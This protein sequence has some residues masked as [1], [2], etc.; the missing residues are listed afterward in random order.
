M[1]IEAGNLES[2]RRASKTPA[3]LR[4]QWAEPWRFYG[5][6]ASALGVALIAA[7]LLLGGRLP[8][9]G[10]GLFAPP[11]D[12]VVHFCVYGL[13]SL[14]LWWALDRGQPWL[15]ALAIF[16]VGAADE[17][18][19]MFLPGREA[20][21]GDLLADMM[22]GILILLTMSWLKGRESRLFP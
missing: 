11:A 2:R 1:P 7:G 8:I 17:W 21:L 4:T 10:S 5:R 18:Q 9:A 20:G 14:L 15:V 12:K 22:G 6:W 3:G 16:L 13:M 19:Q